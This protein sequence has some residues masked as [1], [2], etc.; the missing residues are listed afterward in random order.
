MMKIPK[1]PSSVENWSIEKID[2]LIQYVGIESDTFDFKKEPNQLEEHICAMANTKGGHLVLG[3]EQIDSEDG[4]QIVKFEKRGF[5]HGFEDNIKNQISNSV[6][7]IEPIPDVDIIPV[8]EKDNKKFYIVIQI[9]N[10]FSNKPYFVRSTDQCFVRIHNSKIRANRSIIFNL[11]GT[12]IEQRKNLESLRS[13]SSMVEESF[14][15]VISRIYFVSPESNMKISLLELSYLRTT[16]VSCDAFL[17]ERDLWGE[18]TGQGSYTHGI[19]SLLHDLEFMNTYIKSYNDSHDTDERR[20]LKG[21]LSS[22]SLGSTFE[23][24]TLEMFDKI[25]CSVDVFLSKI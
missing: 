1:I 21:Q 13:A 16:A 2:E 22:Y 6:L 9:Q 7:L 11:F 8:H 23:T 4:K 12:S 5:K 24:Q 10:N 17:K 18:H 3:I 15:H 20:D 25:I 14:R 19:N